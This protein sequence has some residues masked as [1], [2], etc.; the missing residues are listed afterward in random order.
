MPDRQ[1]WKNLRQGWPCLVIFVLLGASHKLVGIWLGPGWTV[2][3]AIL[4][5]IGWL[6]LR[7]WRFGDLSP[8]VRR[9]VCLA[10]GAAGGA[11]LGVFIMISLV[12]Y[13]QAHA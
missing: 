5:E 7:P 12:L 11:A 3:T 8:S 4:A 10:G 13:R 6:T 9:A 1:P 2:V